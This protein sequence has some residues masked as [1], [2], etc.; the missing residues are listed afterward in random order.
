MAGYKKTCVM[1]GTEFT[2]RSFNALYC[3]EYCKKHI[4]YKVQPPMLPRNCITCGTEFQPRTKNHYY[5]STIC[6][7][8][9]K[10]NRVRD[11][12]KEKINAM[13]WMPSHENGAAVNYT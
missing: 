2:A 4:K 7:A 9:A 11:K 12:E 3:S 8:T 5:C 1:C 13:R 6:A 10:N